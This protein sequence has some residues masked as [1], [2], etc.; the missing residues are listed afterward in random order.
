MDDDNLMI[1]IMVKLV[2]MMIMISAQVPSKV[3]NFDL[4]SLAFVFK[5]RTLLLSYRFTAHCFNYDDIDAAFDMH[6][7]Q[8]WV[9][10]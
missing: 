1:V 8:G 3:S 6:T 5:L 10:V 2:R 4:T 9:S 7:F